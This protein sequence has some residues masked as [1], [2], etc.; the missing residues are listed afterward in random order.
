MVLQLTDTL[1]SFSSTG[2]WKGFTK[3][4]KYHSQ[5]QLEVCTVLL[6]PPG[7]TMV[8]WLRLQ[9]L[10]ERG[11]SDNRKLLEVPYDPQRPGRTKQRTGPK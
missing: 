8:V 11:R 4:K 9:L 6:V 2:I 1:S 5:R 7:T 3:G 10:V